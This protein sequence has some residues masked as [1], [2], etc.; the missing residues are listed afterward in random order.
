MG[1]PVAE[2]TWWTSA[3]ANPSAIDSC[4]DGVKYLRQRFIVTDHLHVIT[5]SN[6]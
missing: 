3:Y 4:A 1:S 5:P 6:K 2:L